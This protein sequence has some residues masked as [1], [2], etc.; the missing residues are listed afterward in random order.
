MNQF[1]IDELLAIVE[2]PTV[3]QAR[4]V[5]RDRHEDDAGQ[6]RRLL[7]AEAPDERGLPRLV[8]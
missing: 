6:D 2:H 5:D 8:G 1:V 3:M 7:R 4:Q